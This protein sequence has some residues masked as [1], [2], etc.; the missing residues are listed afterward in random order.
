MSAGEGAFFRD[1]QLHYPKDFRQRVGVMGQ[2]A[3]LAAMTAMN[4][5]ADQLCAGKPAFSE[6]RTG[7]YPSY[8]DE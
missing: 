6:R 1:R 2:K 4:G 5:A 8:R 3:V 7:A